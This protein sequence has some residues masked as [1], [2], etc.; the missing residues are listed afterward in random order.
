M[1]QFLGLV[2]RPLLVS[3]VAVLPT[4]GSLDDARLSDALTANGVAVVCVPA[5]VS[6][7]DGLRYAEQ[8]FGSDLPRLVAA[9]GSSVAAAQRAARTAGIRGAVLLNAQVGRRVGGSMPTMLFVDRSMLTARIW[10]RVASRLGGA[11]L[12]V[13]DASLGAPL[14]SWLL[15]P[16]TIVRDPLVSGSRVAALVAAAALV[17]V[18][19]LPATVNASSNDPYAAGVAVSSAH[20]QGDT[21]PARALAPTSEKDGDGQEVPSTAVQGDGNLSAAA[22]GSQGLVGGNGLKW[23]VNTD[24]TF[25]TSS[26]ASG[27]ASEAS[28]TLAVPATTSAGGTAASTLSDGFDGYNALFVDVA[29]IQ[30]GTDTNA[31][32]QNGPSA[33]DGACGDRQVLFPVTSMQGLDVQ[34]SVY[35]PADGNYA[36]WFNSF[37]NPTGAAITVAVGTSN[38]LGS[39]SNTEITGSSSGDLASQVGD[40]WLTSFQKYSGTTSSDVRLGHVIQGAGAAVAPT[41]INFVNGNDNPYW[42][43][44]IT[45]QPGET[46]SIMNFAVGEY[47]KARAAASAADLAALTPG[48]DGVVNGLRCLTEAQ[49]GSIRNFAVPEISVAP[50]SVNETAGTATVTFTRATSGAAATLTFSVTAGSASAGADYTDPASFVVSFAAGATTASVSI[51]IVNDTAIESDETLQIAITGVTGYGKPS[52]TAASAAVTIVS[53]DVPP[54]TTA[55]PIPT[56]TVPPATLP[57]N[58]QLPATGETSSSL[59]WMAALFAA[60]G[61][62]L[63]GMTRRRPAD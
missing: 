4:D 48:S 56:T 42:A 10:A 57:I 36:R 47:S 12:H 51:P 20:I 60:A 3:A 16:E 15:D 62:L 38:N 23:F 7:E 27:A 35:V 58:I 22:T 31:Y 21:V 53:E 61:A 30:I 14:R 34:R 19:L 32:N 29:G 46:V 55:A 45:V 54:T 37:T 13:V 24:I 44:D 33:L 11:S 5:G 41:I 6:F 25:A 17:A 40:T 50:V 9:S 1:Q 52:A 63:V 39:D 59:G 28:F 49:V 43:W 2:R 26:S 8:E 18:P